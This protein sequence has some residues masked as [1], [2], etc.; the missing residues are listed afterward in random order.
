MERVY[1]AKV[2]L[3]TQLT[4]ALLAFLGS[5][6]MNTICLVHVSLS[7]AICGAPI[8]QKAEEGNGDYAIQSARRWPPCRT[9]RKKE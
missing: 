2:K 9:S 4:G 8:S 3:N 1:A 6:G 7:L 5:F